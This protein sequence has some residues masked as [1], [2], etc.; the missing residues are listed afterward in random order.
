MNFQATKTTEQK[1]RCK[2]Y[3]ANNEELSEELV[4][5]NFFPAIKDRYNALS[6]QI[7]FMG[8]NTLAELAPLRADVDYYRTGSTNII[9]ELGMLTGTV[10]AVVQI[11]DPT[12]NAM[13][14]RPALT[15]A[16]V[17]ELL[18]EAHEM[19]ER[20]ERLLEPLQN[21]QPS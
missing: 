3:L 21:F 1:M 10:T 8:R 7:E 5:S 9:Y 12:V 18:D 4:E 19:V 15:N 16:V 14:D 13:V 6:R 17:E 2:E 11:P 20:I